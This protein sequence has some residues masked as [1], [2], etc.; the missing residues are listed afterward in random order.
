MGR[1]DWSYYPVYISSSAGDYLLLLF[2]RACIGEGS[3]DRTS[4]IVLEYNTLVLQYQAQR[5]IYALATMKV[6]NLNT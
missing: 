2:S 4:R 1:F 5:T 3:W 6:V